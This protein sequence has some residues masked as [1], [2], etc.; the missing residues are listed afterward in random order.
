MSKVDRI[1]AISN[2]LMGMMDHSGMD[3]SHLRDL[4]D[5]GFTLSTDLQGEV[6]PYYGFFARIQSVPMAGEYAQLAE[7]GV[8]ILVHSFSAAKKMVDLAYPIT[9]NP[10]MENKK[11]FLVSQIIQN[12][13]I[14]DET[15]GD[16]LI[17]E[18][19]I[20][21]L[22]TRL[23]PDTY[24][25]KIEALRQVLPIASE[26]LHILKLVP[27]M[28]GGEEPVTYLIM[29][30]NSDEI[31]ATGGFISMMGTLRLDA[32]E[33]TY[34]NVDDISDMNYIS[35]FVRA[36]E[37]MEKILPAYYWLPRDANWSP[38]YPE[39]ARTVQELYFLSTGIKSDGVFAID[40]RTI[41]MIL[42]FTGPVTVDGI[43]LNADNI[44][45]YMISEKM[46]AISQG[47][48]KGRKSFIGPLF[49]GIFDQLQ[50]KANSTSPKELASFFLGLARKG[51]LLL[52][53][54]NGDLENLAKK[55][56]VSGDLIYGTG[57]YLML[58]DSN[59][60]IN[61]ADLVMER[62]LAY[63]VN[64]E[65]VT[66]PSA[67]VVVHYQNPMEGS[68]I[69]K[70]AGD[71]RED[72]TMAYLLPSCYWNYYRILGPAGVEI[73]NFH[74]FDFDDRYFHDGYGWHH[75]PDLG[76][77]SANVSYAGSLLVLPPKTQ[78]DISY[79]RSLPDTIVKN[80]NGTYE[81]SLTIQKQ[82]GVSVLPIQ[83]VIIIPQYSDVLSTN[84]DFPIQI[85]DNQ[86]RVDGKLV[87]STTKFLITFKLQ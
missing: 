16:L 19:S 54:N 45:E 13:D 47:N 26:G 79:D 36:P 22:D 21:E 72:K 8:T 34:L 64:L 20:S 44:R 46:D 51:D 33:I 24:Q 10:L 52:F 48:S 71:I 74:L 77:I 27:A 53:F 80:E 9:Q 25:V 63:T 70:Q 7:P 82:P 57:D 39:S 1:K 58:V 83:L 81:Y 37:P 41:Q 42:Q 78:T 76:E 3:I 2:E 60:G 14:I 5:E 56:Q 12:Q 87:E 73:T 62:S 69:C 11:S 49:A 75:E 65:D 43:T 84:A 38:S 29:V 85:E 17:I 4:V 35:K 61:K 66:K 32:G 86:I 67:E 28:V 55:Y 68:V 6:Q 31:R 59:I 18:Q 40:Q 15:Q 30:Q 23:L 50:A